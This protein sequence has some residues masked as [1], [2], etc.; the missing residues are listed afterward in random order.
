[1]RDWGRTLIRFFGIANWFYGLIGAYFLIDG[2][3]R[4]ARLR[5]I[6]RARPYDSQAYYSLVFINAL[7]LI[8]LLLAGYWL[9]RVNRRCAVFSNYLF[10]F[11]ILY[12][13]GS[14]WASLALSISSNVTAASIGMSLGAVAGIGNM[15]TSVQ[16][17]TAYPLIALVALNIARRRLDRSHS[18]GVLEPSHA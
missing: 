16:F 6:L 1:M 4:H 9:I 15:G 2:E 14:A 5:Q 3:W 17:L 7:F 8:V 12:F 11:E 10:S 18:W 13:I